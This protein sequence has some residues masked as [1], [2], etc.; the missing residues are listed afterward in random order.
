[1]RLRNMFLK[2]QN[3]T[4]PSK[5]KIKLIGYPHNNALSE[6]CSVGNL[7]SIRVS[8]FGV[9]VQYRI[10]DLGGRG[11]LKGVNLVRFQNV[12]NP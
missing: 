12:T 5:I 11:A 6:K 9:K 8:R 2:Y 4:P 7:G 1:M 10:S 3:S